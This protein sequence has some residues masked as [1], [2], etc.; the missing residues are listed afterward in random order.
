MR[1]F[2]VFVSILIFLTFGG[3]AQKISETNV[4]LGISKTSS[5]VQRERWGE[6][7]APTYLTFKATKSWYK[8]DQWISLRKEIGFNLQYS[9]INLSS[10]GL[11]ASNHYTGNIISLFANGCLQAR[12]RI[13]STFALGIGSE[14]EYLL[15][16]YNNLNNSYYTAGT[17]PPGS[18]DIHNKNINRDYFNQPSFGLRLSIFETG[19]SEKATI[20]I[21]VSYLW[22]KSEFSDFYAANYMRISFLIGFKRAKKVLHQKPEE[23][24]ST[25]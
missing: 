4:E 21:N 8:N 19:I 10:G 7:P 6:D 14:A 17:N 12:F 9:N 15:I 3:F 23:S 5:P 16:G 11:G 25:K 1:K 20:G 24:T 2:S 22:T 13:D 18:G